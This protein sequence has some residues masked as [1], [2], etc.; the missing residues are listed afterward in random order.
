M[1]LERIGI[2]LALAGGLLL[3][4]AVAAK[5][6]SVGVGAIALANLGIAMTALSGAAPLGGRLART[7]LAI[8][9][10]GLATFAVAAILI[11]EVHPGVDALQIGLLVTVLLG[12]TATAIGSM[13]LV[14]ASVRTIRAH[15]AMCGIAALLASLVLVGLASYT[16][17]VGAVGSDELAHPVGNT[18]CRTPMSRFGWT[19]EAINYDIA[20]DANLAQSNPDMT[21]CANQGMRAGQ[22]VTT[23]D[24]IP[25]AGWY[26]PAADGIGPTGPTVV[27]AHG[28]G[29]N[30]SEVLKYA[31]P[32]H[33]S[34]N[35]VAFDERDSG[36]SGVADSTFGMREQL[37]LEAVIN[38]VERTKHPVHL[39]VMG[40]SMGGGASTLAAAGDPR[41]E[42]LILD[43]THAHV[44]N[45]LETRLEVDAGGHPGIPGAP[46][47]LAGFWLR[48]GV[49][50]MQ[51]DPI[52]KIAALGKRPLL[53]I[54]GTADV[55]DVPALSV[56][57]IDKHAV[58][59]GVPVEIHLCPGATHGKVIDTCPTAWGTWAVG[60]LD[61]VF[62]LPN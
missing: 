14:V 3:V 15:R 33:P 19:Y 57:L 23:S 1:R 43:S 26:I 60:F 61:R 47:I 34:F 54:H 41:I 12:I 6:S 51:A 36:R 46:A 59:L 24:G 38:W 8:A 5:S 11:D 52:S 29:A 44:S 40:N 32:F 16:M 4:T 9:G 35:V 58:A 42:A 30:K 48:T 10:L 62:D 25:I 55:N 37:D 7:G 21:N 13:V 17:Y 45:V 27:L 20:D 31:V 56:E 2:A 22:A 53:L 50:L 49:D 28:W 18:D 39:A